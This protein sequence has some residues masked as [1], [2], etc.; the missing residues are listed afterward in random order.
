MPVTTSSRSTAPKP[1]PSFIFKLSLFIS[2]PDQGSL[3]YSR[4]RARAHLFPSASEAHTLGESREN[5]GG[6]P[7]E[8]G[9]CS[10][11]YHRDLPEGHDWRGLWASDRSFH[12]V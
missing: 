3:G 4:T 6:D 7:H 2:F 9:T 8:Y 12:R 11:T 1:A 5:A 10:A